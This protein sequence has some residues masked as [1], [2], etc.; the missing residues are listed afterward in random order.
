M[1]LNPTLEYKHISEWA[2]HLVGR[3]I[4]PRNLVKTLGKHLNK[5][6]PVR[7][8][9]YSGAKGAL[10]PGEFSIG[11]EYDPGLDEI[12]KK[13]FIID[14]ILNYP[15]TTPHAIYRRTSRKDNYRSSRDISS[16]I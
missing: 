6:H 11:A 2:N 1:Y 15:K 7:V 9:L 13:Q 5:H 12:R 10:D 16:R 8:K 3:R 14:F 4:T